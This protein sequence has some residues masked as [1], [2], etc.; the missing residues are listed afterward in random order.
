ME[1]MTAL[2]VEPGY[3]GDLAVQCALLHDVLED[4]PIAYAQLEARFGPL[5]AQGVAALTKNASLPKSEQMGESLARI[6]QQPTEVW[7][8]KLADRITNLQPP[9][10]GWTSAKRQRYRDEAREIYHALGSASPFLAARLQ[11]HIE[12]YGAFF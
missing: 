8:V 1:V 6:R 12:Q 2:T 11:N 10:V 5:V 9:P 4:T 3:D 7:M